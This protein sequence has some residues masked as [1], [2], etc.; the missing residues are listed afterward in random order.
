MARSAVTT[1]DQYLGE[2]TEERRGVVSKVRDLIR[3]HLPKG[4]EESVGWGMITY[5]LPLEWYPN[6]YNGQP[7]CYAGLAS[8]KNYCS[9]YVMSAYANAED[10]GALRRGFAEAGKKLD[11]G[12]SCIR[13]KS[14]DDLPLQVIADVIA[15]TTPDDF[16][17]EYESARARAAKSAQRT[18]AKSKKKTPAR[19]AAAKKKQ[20]SP[21]ASASAQK[22]KARKKG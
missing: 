22:A 3:R 6:T 16:V 11:M 1:V 15:R 21:R 7:L 14:V 17:R 9:L 20:P 4:Y 13:F 18:R 10:A 12:K 2:L 19:T 5:S 8:Q